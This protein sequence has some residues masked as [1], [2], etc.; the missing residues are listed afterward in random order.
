MKNKTNK[1]TKPQKQNQNQIGKQTRKQ[2]Q[3]ESY[4][5]RK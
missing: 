4:G 5:E 1:Q 2:L 3:S